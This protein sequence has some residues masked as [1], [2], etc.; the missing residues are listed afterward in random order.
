MKKIKSLSFY[1]MIMFPY[2]LSSLLL[3]FT[4]M[5]SDASFATDVESLKT[6]LGMDSNQFNIMMIAVLTISNF[7]I[8]FVV[9]YILKLFIFL[10]DK[11]K[12]ARNKDLFFSLLTGYTIA[13][14]CALIINDFF[15]VPID[16]AAK[17]MTF[18]DVI[19]FA[20]LYYYF[21]KLKKISIILCIIKL[22]ISLPGVFV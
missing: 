20:G 10:F 12:V 3:F 2:L 13:N 15:N 4:L 18:M 14:L 8:F 21:S 6:I 17:I 1:S 22:I 16:I 11:A 5:S 19:I 9:F 7:V